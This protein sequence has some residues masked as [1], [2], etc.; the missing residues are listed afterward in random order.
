MSHVRKLFDDN[1]VE[2][3]ERATSEF[4]GIEFMGIESIG[5]E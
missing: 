5:P 3:A 2:R 4:I 1:A